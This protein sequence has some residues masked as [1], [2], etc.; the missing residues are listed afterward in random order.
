MDSRD[1]CRAE[2]V[3]F[4]IIYFGLRWGQGLGNRAAHPEQKFPRVTPYYTA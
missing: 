4:K 3:Y 2:K 1:P